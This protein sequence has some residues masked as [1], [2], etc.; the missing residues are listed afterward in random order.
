[1]CVCVC[2]CECMLMTVCVCVCVC[3]QTECHMQRQ[4]HFNMHKHTHTHDYTSLTQMYNKRVSN[5][6]YVSKVPA[7][8]GIYSFPGP[9]VLG[10]EPIH[11]YR[12]FQRQKGFHHSL[13]QTQT[14][15]FFPIIKCYIYLSQTDVDWINIIC[16]CTDRYKNTV[17][18][19]NLCLYYKYNVMQ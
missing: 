10:P 1:M 14:L 13:N 9:D 16:D 11:L 18:V 6:L 17:Y 19:D 7:M 4:T 12:L 2:D 15:C 8:Y 5:R 3:V